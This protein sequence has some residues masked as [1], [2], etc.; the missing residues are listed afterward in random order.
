MKLS[1]F[2]ALTKEQKRYTVLREGVPIAKRQ[3]LHHMVFLFQLPEYY[4]E[5]FCSFES[6]EI[7]EFRIFQDPK[8][9]TPY[10]DAIPLDNLLS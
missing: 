6:K 10:L 9:L 1:E 7:R 4:V 2:I 5:T 3:V 8:Y